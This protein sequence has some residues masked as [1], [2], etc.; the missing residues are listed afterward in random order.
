MILLDFENLVED[1]A[2]TVKNFGGHK[3]AAFLLSVEENM[4]EVQETFHE[5]RHLLQNYDKSLG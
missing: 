3:D 4:T 2:K 5:I 1:I